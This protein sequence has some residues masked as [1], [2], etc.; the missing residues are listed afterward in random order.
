MRACMR[1]RVRACVHARIC[2]C[3]CVYVQ[4]HIPDREGNSRAQVVVKTAV[5]LTGYSDCLTN[6]HE[7]VSPP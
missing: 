6:F 1:A 4:P 2:V 7:P 3:V 5:Y